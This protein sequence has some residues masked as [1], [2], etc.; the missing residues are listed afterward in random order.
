MFFFFFTIFQQ[1][2]R[3]DRRFFFFFLR[4]C[5]LDIECSDNNTEWIIEENGERWWNRNETN[6]RMALLEFKGGEFKA[7]TGTVQNS[8]VAIPWNKEWKKEEEGRKKKREWLVITEQLLNVK[9]NRWR[10]RSVLFAWYSK[11]AETK[12]LY[13]FEFSNSPLFDQSFLN[14]LRLE[15]LV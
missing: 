8:I 1:N 13:P 6:A 2:S 14:S 5:R 12:F 3:V 15:K 9:K 7:S 4:L 11:F 10:E